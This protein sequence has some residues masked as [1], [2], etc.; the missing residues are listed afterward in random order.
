MK[1]LTPAEILS[2]LDCKVETLEI[3]EWGGAVHFRP[4]SGAERD[5]FDQR[6][7]KDREGGHMPGRA[8]I[9]SMVLCDADGNRIFAES[10]AD[11]LG[12]KNASAL[13]RIVNRAMQT[14]LLGDS[15]VEA[16]SGN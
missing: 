10:D 7:M 3:P 5:V 16:A 15:G 2:A 6:V 4:M 11:A 1:I 12:K 14:G 8:L 9:A 13:S